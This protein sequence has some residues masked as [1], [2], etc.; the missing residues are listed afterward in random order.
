MENETQVTL[1]QGLPKG[2]KMDEIV[3]KAT[4]LGVFRIVPV[5]TERSIPGIGDISAKKYDRW[6]RIAK[7]ASRQSMRVKVPGI[8]EVSTLAELSDGLAYEG[9]DLIL[10]L[11]ELE[12]G[13]TLKEALRGI[14]GRKIAV[15]IGPEGGFE[16]S[17]IELL[18]QHGA[19]SVTIGDTILRTETAGPAAVA[20]ILYELTL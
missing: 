15:F 7:E 9:Y 10:I 4:E 11:Y 6:K 1:Y 8:D 12:E 3:R 17:E 19:F 14:N 20:M 13:R 2:A 16:S 5:E 18:I